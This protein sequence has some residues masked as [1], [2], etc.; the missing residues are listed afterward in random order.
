MVQVVGEDVQESVRAFLDGHSHLPADFLAPPCRYWAYV[1][2]D[3][4]VVGTVGLEYG[5]G[6]GLLRTAFIHPTHRG[7]GIG[8]VLVAALLAEARRAGLR[9]VYLFS[10]SAGAYWE[11]LGFRRVPVPEAA[12][13]LPDAPQVR[14]YRARGCLG[15][16][17]AYRL[18]LEVRAEPGAEADR[19]RPSGFA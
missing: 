11:R 18:E 10:T 1:L 2:P 17:V 8:R 13:A 14:D 7:A 12:A 16:E 6:C 4:A 9:R 19:G 5:R 15:T 3:G